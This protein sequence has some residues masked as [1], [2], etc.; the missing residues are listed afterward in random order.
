MTAPNTPG[1]PAGTPLAAPTP[2]GR[3]LRIALAISLAINLGVAGVMAG[4]MFRNHKYNQDGMA[5]RDLGF[6]PFTEALSKEDRGALRRAFLTKVPEMRDGRRAMRLDF[7]ALLGQLRAVPF[8][9]AGLR[10]VFDRQNA[11]NTERLQLGQDLIF[12]LVVGM[13]DDAR[14]GFADRL[15]DELSRSPQRREKPADP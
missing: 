10:E 4:A 9:A 15:E 8:D 3:W 6:G 13:T 1:D 12:D 2:S 5:A 7:S 11:R 14:Q